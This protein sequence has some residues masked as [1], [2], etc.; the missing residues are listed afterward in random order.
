MLRIKA[1]LRVERGLLPASAHLQV[2]GQQQL[3]AAW[4]VSPPAPPPGLSEPS[5]G[6]KHTGKVFCV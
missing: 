3:R 6:V 4:C 2:G 1:G 5:R